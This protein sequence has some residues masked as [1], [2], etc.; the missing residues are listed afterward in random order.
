LKIPKISED[1]PTASKD[2]RRLPRSR[3]RLS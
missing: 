1:D 3:R 2:V